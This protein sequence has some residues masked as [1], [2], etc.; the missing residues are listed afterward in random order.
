MR[1]IT[2]MAKPLSMKSDPKV[3]IPTEIGIKKKAKCLT[4]MEEAPSTHFE[5]IIPNHNN[6]KRIT[7]P[8][9]FPGIGSPLHLTKNIPS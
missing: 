2:I 6:K 3:I 1:R 9:T 7:I 5:G 8:R 4:K